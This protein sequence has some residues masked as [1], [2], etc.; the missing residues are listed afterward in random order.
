MEV[1]PIPSVFPQ[2]EWFWG[3]SPSQS[4]L[5]D[6]LQFVNFPVNVPLDAESSTPDVVFKVRCL[7][8]SLASAMSTEHWHPITPTQV[9]SFWTSEPCLPAKPGSFNF[10]HVILDS[11]YRAGCLY[12]FIFIQLALTY[13]FPGMPE[14][15]KILV[16]LSHN[17]LAISLHLVSSENFTVMKS[18]G[19][20]PS[21]SLVKILITT[22]LRPKP[23]VLLL[24]RSG[25][26][27]V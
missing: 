18:S 25:V 6:L 8:V 3:S 24:L 13:F 7:G 27:G 20:C 19:L 14:P 10:G 2:T 5:L 23:A 9:S 1:L 26:S 12:V 21:S 17:V 22:I 4:S 16:Q 11:N 15:F